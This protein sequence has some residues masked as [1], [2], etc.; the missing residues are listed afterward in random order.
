MPES[1]NSEFLDKIKREVDSK[2]EPQR[3]KDI[4][5]RQVGHVPANLFKI[6]SCLLSEGYVNCLSCSYGGKAAST[7]R[8]SSQQAFKKAATQHGKDPAGGEVELTCSN[9]LRTR[10]EDIH[11]AQR[12]FNEK[13]QLTSEIEGKDQ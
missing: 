6:Y 12:L 4:I 13:L 7:T 9:F 1:V 11:T 3:V 10:D 2:R 8:L 5:G